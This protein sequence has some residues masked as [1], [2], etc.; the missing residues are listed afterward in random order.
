MKAI[1]V[2]FLAPIKAEDRPIVD[3]LKHLEEQG[4]IR[5][6]Y[7]EFLVLGQTRMI[8]AGLEKSPLSRVLRN[9]AGFLSLLVTRKRVLLIGTEPFRLL[10]LLL[11]LLKRRQRCVYHTSWAWD[12]ENF[13][14]RT[15]VPFRRAIWRKFLAGLP[16]VSFTREGAKGLARYGARA[17]YIPHNVDT[18]IFH[19]AESPRAGDAVN[20]LFAGH[21]NRIKGV[22]LIVEMIRKNDWTHFH[23][24]FLGQGPLEAEIRNLEK[25]KH[26]VRYLGIIRNRETLAG[27][28]RDA[29]MLILP[30]VRMGREEERFGMVLIEAMAC[31]VPVIASDCVGPRQIVEHEKNGLLIPQN[32]GQALADA[33]RRLGSAPD[34]R[35]RL[36]AYGRKQA[37][38]I[39]DKKAV[40]RQ[41]LEVIQAAAG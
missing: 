16:C 26:P 19:P 23:F 33:I 20:V 30:S 17:F 13:S 5:V 14:D 31:G 29:D 4:W 37:E 34:L 40:A 24:L 1:P 22:D 36:G 9:I 18:E 15:W 2:Y 7:L 21:L 39:Y 41:W 11:P 27:V 38:D 25:E 35:A 32:D 8:L 12:E 6:R 28:Y 10:T 3:P